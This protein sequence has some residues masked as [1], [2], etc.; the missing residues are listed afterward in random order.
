MGL[1]G[2]VAVLNTVFIN[3]VNTLCIALAEKSRLSGRLQACASA[4]GYAA[5]P[6]GCMTLA[7]R[8]K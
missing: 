7:M 5:A 6:S 1:S 2:G 4:L 3:G 8:A